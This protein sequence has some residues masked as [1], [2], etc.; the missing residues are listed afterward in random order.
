M[1]SG[2][3]GLA[4]FEKGHNPLRKFAKTLFKCYFSWTFYHCVTFADLGDNRTDW[5]FLDGF[6]CGF[7][8]IQL[9]TLKL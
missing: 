7:R 5:K 2:G 8:K 9:K 3:A 1:M 4:I 6:K